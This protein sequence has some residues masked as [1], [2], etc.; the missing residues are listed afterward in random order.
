M[1]Y[2]VYGPLVRN[3]RLLAALKPTLTTSCLQAAKQTSLHWNITAV[4]KDFV[5]FVLVLVF[6]SILRK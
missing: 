4:Y 1:M 5:E 2:Y 3:Q 6:G